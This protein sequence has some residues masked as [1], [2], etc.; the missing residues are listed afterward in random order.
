MESMRTA[1]MG[2]RRAPAGKAERSP[3]YFGY[4]ATV[5]TPPGTGLARK[6]YAEMR[7]P[8][9]PNA[10]SIQKASGQSVAEPRYPF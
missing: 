9:S 1:Q 5:R 4:A 8:Y 6:S 3:P 7:N 10:S 2:A